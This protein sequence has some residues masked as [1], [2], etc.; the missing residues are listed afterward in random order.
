MQLGK[1]KK[2][3]AEQKEVIEAMYGEMEVKLLEKLAEC[4]IK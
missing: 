1:L 2:Q 4:G 3:I